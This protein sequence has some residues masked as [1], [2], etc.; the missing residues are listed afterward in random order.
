[1]RTY[2]LTL[3]ALLAAAPLALAAQT[4]H[5]HP[6]DLTVHTLAGSWYVVAEDC[7]PLADCIVDLWVVE[8]RNG[9]P[10][11]QVDAEG[12]YEPDCA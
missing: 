1:M 4:C 5:D 8:E 11:L 3:A 2:V 9:V 7:D 10:G 6:A 12:N